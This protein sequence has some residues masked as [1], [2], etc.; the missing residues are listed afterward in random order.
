MG[1]RF[2][3]SLTSCQLLAVSVKYLLRK[4]RRCKLKS[5][6]SPVDDVYVRSRCHPIGSG[7]VRG[8]WYIPGK[9]SYPLL[10]L[11]LPFYHYSVGQTKPICKMLKFKDKH[12][13]FF[14]VT[15]NYLTPLFRWRSPF[16]GTFSF[17]PDQSAEITERKSFLLMYNTPLLTQF[18]N[19][20]QKNFTLK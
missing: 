13:N 1:K 6:G 11:P 8:R 19:T 15:G 2:P 9:F 7:G 17:R 16:R 5:L 10:P 4:F 12:K 14:S 18:Y 3:S 20:V